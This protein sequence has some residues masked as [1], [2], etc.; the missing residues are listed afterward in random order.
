MQPA[1]RHSLFC[2]ILHTPLNPRTFACGD[3]LHPG[4]RRQG[5]A[6]EKKPCKGYDKRDARGETPPE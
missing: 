5:G 3:F 6:V 4:R 2:T 1:K